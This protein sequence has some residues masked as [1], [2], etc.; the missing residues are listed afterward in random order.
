MVKWDMESDRDNGGG[1]VEREG[2][3]QGARNKRRKR[4]RGGEPQREMRETEN[5]T[6]CSLTSLLE[7]RVGW[8]CCCCVLCRDRSGRS[9]L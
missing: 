7:D 6:E 5:E 3:M 2:Q 4:A 8:L 1:D 9:G